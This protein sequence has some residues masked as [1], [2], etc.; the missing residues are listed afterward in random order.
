MELLFFTDISQVQYVLDKEPELFEQMRPIT[1]DIVVAYELDRLN[2]GF[3]DE[4][5]FLESADIERN[6][7]IANRLSASWWNEINTNA[8]YEGFSLFETTKQDIVYPIEACLNARVVY[9]RIF[10]ENSINRISGF[11]LTSIGVIR[12]GPSPSQRAVRS[13]SQAVLFWLAEKFNISVNKLETD[14]PLSKGNWTRKRFSFADFKSSRSKK[15][16]LFSEKIAVVV[17]DMMTTSEHEALKDTLGKLAEW[18]V[19]SI[20][21]SDLEQHSFENQTDSDAKRQ[22]QCSWEAFIKTS[23]SFNGIY[24]EIF[25]NQYLDFQFTRIWDEMKTAIDYGN[26]FSTFLDIL[27]PSIVFFG[28]EAF[29]LDRVLVLLAKKSN[30]PTVGFVHGGM[31][32]RLGYRGIAGDVDIILSWND[33]D[34][35]ILKSYGFDESRIYKIGCIRFESELKKYIQKSSDFEKGLKKKILQRYGISSNNPIILIITTAINAGFSAPIANAR[36]HREALK[37]L[38]T[39]IKSRTDLQ[40]IIKAHP[41]ND[42]YE[43]YRRMH[44]LNLPN[45]TFLENATLDE[46]I[47]VSDVC[48]MVNYFTTAALEAMLHQLPVIYLKNAIYPLKDWEDN[49]PGFILNRVYSI[50]ELENHIDRLITDHVFREQTL[51]EADNIIHEILDVSEKSTSERLFGFIKNIKTRQQEPDLGARVVHAICGKQPSDSNSLEEIGDFLN[52][53]MLK[54]SIENSLHA[55]S[56]LAG[57]NNMGISGIHKLF[58]TIQQYFGKE[59]LHSWSELRWTLLK[60]YISGYNKGTP[61]GDIYS[62]LCLIGLLLKY[63]KKIIYSS[64][65]I[66]NDVIKYLVKAIVGNNSVSIA[67]INRS[68]NSVRKIVSYISA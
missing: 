22:L 52:E 10:Q 44:N 66:K 67:I 50:Q 29:T 6:W 19:I 54:H 34:N 12:T 4:W 14:Y 23:K 64:I 2:I 7:E 38:L 13:V 63:P 35:D 21:H 56:F 17:Y 36:K 30:I 9:E 16:N 37:E 60:A 43:L 57:R 32:Y 5:D 28:H 27:K 18:Q 40:F 53:I 68:I 20:S 47:E 45:L 8:Y 33:S 49:I 1:G 26:M 3:I 51:T 11:F 41:G 31:G 24:P 46:A 58:D 61:G 55:F 62:V 65:L 59:N 42:Y 25:A 15:S 48:M 39:L